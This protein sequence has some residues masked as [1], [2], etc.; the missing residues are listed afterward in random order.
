MAE[1]CEYGDGGS[2]SGATELLIIIIIIIIT[3]VREA[4]ENSI[5]A[6]CGSR[7]SYSVPLI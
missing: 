7:P 2:G 4:Q 6:A 5:R 1:C 3:V